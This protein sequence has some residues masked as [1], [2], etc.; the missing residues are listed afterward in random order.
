MPP[1]PPALTSYYSR[2]RSGTQRIFARIL[3]NPVTRENLS[4][5]ASAALLEKI[6]RSGAGS[7][8]GENCSTLAFLFPVNSKAFRV[9]RLDGNR[10]FL[11]PGRC[12]SI[13]QHFSQPQGVRTE[14]SSPS[15]VISTRLK[16]RP[17]IF[18]YD[19]LRGI[20][21]LR[22]I[23]RIDQIR[24][25]ISK[26]VSAFL[27]LLQLNAIQCLHLFRVIRFILNP[28]TINRHT[29][30]AVSAVRLQTSHPHPYRAGENFLGMSYDKCPAPLPAASPKD[31]GSQAVYRCSFPLR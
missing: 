7:L 2:K 21:A 24:V 12:Q 16:P 30:P 15:S 11:G 1:H 8:A 19:R 9:T 17:D 29:Y 3:Q 13:V 31:Q 25:K 27:S 28:P 22:Q 6:L 5:P 18:P 10:I 23:R 26:I 14:S 4:S 20:Y